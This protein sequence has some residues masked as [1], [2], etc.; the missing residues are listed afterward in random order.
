S[1][2]HLAD[3]ATL[4][5]QSGREYDDIFPVW[6][7]RQIPGVT[8][9]QGDE[10]LRWPARKDRSPMTDFVGAASDGSHAVA[11]MDFSQR[12]VRAHKAWVFVDNV[13]VCL[14]AGISSSEAA[15]VVTTINQCL[16][17]GDVQAND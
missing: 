3:G 7:W 4:F 10:S 9:A 11:G 2:L 1:G 8:C 13:I 6:N 17:H 16:L 12:G 14:G 15:P 5:Y